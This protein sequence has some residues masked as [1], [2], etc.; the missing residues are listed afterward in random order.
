MEDLVKQTKN[1]VIIKNTMMPIMNIVVNEVNMPKRCIY[2]RKEMKKK[3]KKERGKKWL[4]KHKLSI[5]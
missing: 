3:K 1:T 5:T 4:Y 2:A